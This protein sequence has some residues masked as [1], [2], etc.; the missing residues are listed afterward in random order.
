MAVTL[1]DCC[2][3]FFSVIIPPVGVFLQTGCDVHLAICILLTLLGKLHPW[4][5]ICHICYCVRIN[6][7]QQCSAAV[8]YGK[9]PIIN[10]LFCFY[11]CKIAQ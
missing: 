7:D 11:S 2:R 8:L 5:N 1:G 6:N 10:I 3:I 9:I 4:V